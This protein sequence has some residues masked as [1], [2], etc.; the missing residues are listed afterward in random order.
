MPRLHGTLSIDS[1][2]LV[3]SPLAKL[4]ANADDPQRARRPWQKPSPCAR[5]GWLDSGAGGRT[6]RRSCHR[7]Q[8]DRERQARSAGLDVGTTRQG[9]RSLASR[10]AALTS[11]PVPG[12]VRAAGDRLIARSAYRTFTICRRGTTES[13]DAIFILA[14]PPPARQRPA[15]CW[16]GRGE[17]KKFLSAGFLVSVHHLRTW[18]KDM[19][20]RC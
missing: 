5:A 8:P 3:K 9:P 17:G 13:T 2:E 6:Q 10:S 15:V 7:G 20:G 19:L 12:P 4:V 1:L 16:G 18:A 14:H 11:R